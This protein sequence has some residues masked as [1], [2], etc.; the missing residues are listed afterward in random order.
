MKNIA[1]KTAV[2]VDILSKISII[3]R[4]LMELKLSVL[5]ELAPAGEKI[6]SLKG[7]LKGI[8]V[9]EEDISLSKQSLYSTI[10]P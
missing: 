8:D 9:T 3:E 7:I 10:D 2:T 1:G 5:R 4:D 6:I